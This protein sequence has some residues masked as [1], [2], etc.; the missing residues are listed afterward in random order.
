MGSLPVKNLV[1]L[2]FESLDA[3]A[4]FFK[5]GQSL[6]KLLL[7]SMDVSCSVMIQTLMHIMF[8]TRTSVVLK[9][10]VT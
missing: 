5:R 4:I 10:H 3:S 9:P 1:C 7:K 8:S 2:T 6:L